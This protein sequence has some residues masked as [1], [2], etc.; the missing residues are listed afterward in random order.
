MECL[1]KIS[2]LDEPSFSRGSFNLKYSWD[3]TSFLDSSSKYLLLS[4]P[5]IREFETIII[6]E[7][8]LNIGSNWRKLKLQCWIEKWK[9]KSSDEEGEDIFKK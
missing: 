2:F 9:F 7:Q 1:E 8:D 4:I 3:L 5:K 6:L